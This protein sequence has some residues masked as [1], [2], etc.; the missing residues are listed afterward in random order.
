MQNK[1]LKLLLFFLLSLFLSF[2]TLEGQDSLHT[3]KKPVFI[4]ATFYYDFPQAFG[5]ASGL[6]FPISSKLKITYEKNGTE[7]ISHRD[8][9]ISGDVG[10]YRYRFNHSGLYFTPAIG[11]RYYDIRPHYFEMLLSLGVL[12]TFYDGRVYTVGDDGYVK[13]KKNFG[14]YYFTSGFSVAFGHDFERS[15]NPKPFAV[16]VRP[17]FWIQY[18]YNSYLL[19]HLSVELSF[20]YHF[21]RFNVSVK[22]K[23]LL[24]H[25]NK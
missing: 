7:K 24:S 8:L 17:S 22:Q 16:Q 21:N 25:S 23:Q 11:K 14:R 2:S 19:P 15:H 5:F 20:K 12:R 18:P 10:F 3:V 4:H 1:H 9:I 13:E 6:D